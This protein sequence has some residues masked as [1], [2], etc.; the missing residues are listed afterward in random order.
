M[1]KSAR[2]RWWRFVLSSEDEQW[3]H[4]SMVLRRIDHGQGQPVVGELRHV[5]GEARTSNQAVNGQQSTK[6][7]N[8]TIVWFLRAVVLSSHCDENSNQHDADR[9]SLL[10]LGT[11]SAIRRKRRSSVATLQQP[12]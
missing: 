3:I 6:P 8:T 12:M 5:S 10:L 7:T 2:K 11:D 1:H 4:Q 9:Y